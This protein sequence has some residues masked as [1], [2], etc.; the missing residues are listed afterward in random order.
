MDWLVQQCPSA[1]EYVAPPEVESED[2]D[3][4]EEGKDLDPGMFRGEGI[5]IVFGPSTSGGQGD[6]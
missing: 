3:E 1:A 5:E 6:E 2:S 4:D